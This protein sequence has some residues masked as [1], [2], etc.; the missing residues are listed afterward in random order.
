MSL[1][2]VVECERQGEG[3]DRHRRSRQPSHTQGLL[4]LWETPCLLSLVTPFAG[5]F[6]APQ[7][8]YSDSQDDC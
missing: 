6:L 5:F 7:A 1:E 4:W 8:P 2:E 3:I